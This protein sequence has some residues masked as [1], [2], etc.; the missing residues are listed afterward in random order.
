MSL[1]R[2]LRGWKTEIKFYLIHMNQTHNM[3]PFLAEIC[4][5]NSF[6]SGLIL[7][8]A[9]TQRIES[10]LDENNIHSWDFLHSYNPH[11]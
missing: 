4:K 1:T 2:D 6:L 11:N 8:W 3:Y 10:D 7:S 9:D 5:G